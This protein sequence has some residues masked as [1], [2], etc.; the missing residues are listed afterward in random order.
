MI[1]RHDIFSLVAMQVVDI[2]SF[3]KTDDIAKLREF[4][5]PVIVRIIDGEV[6]FIQD[7][8][9][10]LLV[11]HYATRRGELSIATHLIMLKKCPENMSVLYVVSNG[12]PKY[13]AFNIPK[14]PSRL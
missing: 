6:R 7:L 2:K 12:K 1:I 8:D 11:T 5:V 10:E 9:I 13:Y 3:L 4:R 14:I